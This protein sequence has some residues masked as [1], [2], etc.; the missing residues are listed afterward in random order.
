MAIKLVLNN[1]DELEEYTFD[2]E[3]IS[4]GRDQ[5][6]DLHI[7]DTSRVVS[8][9]HAE[10]LC[11]NDRYEVVDLG[12]KNFTYLNNIRLESGRTYELSHGDWI[13][14]GEFELEFKIL[15]P[16]PEL[17]E[18]PETARVSHREFDKTVFESSFVNPFA[19]D[20]A[21]L[22][23]AFNNLCTAYEDETPNRRMD[24]LKDAFDG[25]SLQD[26]IEAQQ[27][28]MRVLELSPDAEATDPVV[29][30]ASKNAKNGE[31]QL[32]PVLHDDR[33]VPHDKALARVPQKSQ[34]EFSEQQ[35]RVWQI[36]LNVLSMLLSIPWEFRHEFV[37]HT[38]AQTPE[39]EILF[40]GNGSKL[41]NYLLDP[42]L[43]DEELTR[44]LAL[45]EEGGDE[46]I[47]HQL[48]MLE[49]YKAVVQQGMH[50][51][52][53]EIDPIVA[54]ENLSQEGG[55]YKMIP[56]MAQLVASWRLQEKFRELR[57]ED[58][59]VTERRAYRP[60]FIR[61]YLSR[62]SAGPKKTPA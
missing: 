2:Q 12:S 20:A 9:R 28:V 60:S 50:M 5:D 57:A 19:E 33:S 43:D 21:R 35:E 54:A 22:V 48:A 47:L 10:I 3:R 53:R 62:M 51:L 36:V 30:V 24:A 4:L 15:R 45:I 7:P 49:G 61:A 58:W 29:R 44:R 59:S 17:E 8:K 32:V 1:N 18:E 25:L 14:L 56:S 55:V 31:N 13:K 38:I 23:V 39:S 41:R 37:G 16:E 42:R 52:L 46:V 6:N 27:A 40:E 11:E 34:I 26:N